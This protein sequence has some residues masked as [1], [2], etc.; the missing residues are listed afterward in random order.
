MT[1]TRPLAHLAEREDVDTLYVH[2][3]GA[4]T[5][6]NMF[7]HVEKIKEAFGAGEEYAKAAS[8]L[9]YCIDKLFQQGFA[10]EAYITKDS[11]ETPGK[12][13]LVQCGDRFVFGIVWFRDRKYDGTPLEG[14]AGDWSA[15]S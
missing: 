1:A 14:I 5:I 12:S 11:V 8:S 3:L 10:P 15:H 6:H 9:G 2:R 4:E 13:L 7:V